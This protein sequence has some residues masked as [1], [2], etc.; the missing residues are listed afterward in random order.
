MPDCA[1]LSSKASTSAMVLGF[2]VSVARRLSGARAGVSS[3]GFE[4]DRNE[5]RLNRPC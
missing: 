4:V 2:T 1:I 3:L 5:G